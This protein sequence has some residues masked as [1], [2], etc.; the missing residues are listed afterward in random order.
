[1]NLVKMVANA[2]VVL[3]RSLL[4]RACANLH[5][6]S[7]SNHVRI[8]TIEEFR[9]VQAVNVEGVLHCFRYAALQMIQQG[10]GGRIIGRVYRQVIS[11]AMN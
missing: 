9:H 2:G 6:S 8:V 11:F 7:C 3:F 10:R 5:P 4:D 1:M